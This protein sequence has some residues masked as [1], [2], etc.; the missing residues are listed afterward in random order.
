MLLITDGYSEVEETW[1]PK[2]LDLPCGYKRASDWLVGGHVVTRHVPGL[3]VVAGRRR[4]RAVPGSE[5]LLRV[6]SR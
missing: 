1:L 4:R 5:L 6:C 2:I 3:H